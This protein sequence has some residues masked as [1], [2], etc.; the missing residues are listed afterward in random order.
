MSKQARGADLRVADTELAVACILDLDAVVV[1]GALKLV[2]NIQIGLEGDLAR[3]KVEADDV[4]EVVKVRSECGNDAL[5]K[6][7]E[8]RVAWS[9]DGVCVLGIV[10]LVIKSKLLKVGLCKKK[11]LVIMIS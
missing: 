7:G 11:L 1:K 5:V 4:S 9:E 2:S 10:K 8:A 6:V 3:D